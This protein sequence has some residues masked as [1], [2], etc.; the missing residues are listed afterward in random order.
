MALCKAGEAKG[1]AMIGGDEMKKKPGFR[2]NERRMNFT[3]AWR[4][5]AMSESLVGNPHSLKQS[6]FGG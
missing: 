6:C 4:K 5:Q 3:T 1:Y 2:R